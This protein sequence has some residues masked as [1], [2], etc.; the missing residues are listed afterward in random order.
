MLGLS[1]WWTHNL[2]CCSTFLYF[3]RIQCATSLPCGCITKLGSF[4]LRNIISM[5]LSSEAALDGSA[6]LHYSP[7]SAVAPAVGWCTLVD[8][9][10]PALQKQRFSVV[11]QVLHAVPDCHTHQ[12]HRLTCGRAGAS[13]MQIH[14]THSLC[15]CA[16][17]QILDAM[18]LS[19][20]L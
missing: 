18:D 12:H 2:G 9:S 17:L 16:A 14:F 3:F 10:K 20:D 1:G 13:S 7:S 15:D 8:T 19:L 6:T 5:R 4:Y 11:S